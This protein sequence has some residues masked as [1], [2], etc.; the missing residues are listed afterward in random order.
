MTSGDFIDM[1]TRDVLEVLKYIM[2][3]EVFQMEVPYSGD[4][5]HITP[6]NEEVRTSK[7]L[8]DSQKTEQNKSLGHQLGD[9]NIADHEQI[10]NGYKDVL[11]KNS[12]SMKIMES[13]QIGIRNSIGSMS[14][15][16]ERDILMKDFMTVECTKFSYHDTTT[17]KQSEF[18]FK[19]Y[20]P[21][22]F[23][24]FRG[25]FGI[26]HEDFVTSI[27]GGPLLE[28][29]NPGVSGSIFYISQKDKFIT[30]TVQ[31][32]EAT[33]LQ[34]LLPGY[35]LNLNQN[36]DTLLPKFFGLYCYNC[37]SKNVRM[38]VMNNI[39]PYSES[40]HLKYD[41]KGSRYMR[42]ASVT[43]RNKICPT[44]KDLDFLDHHPGGLFL[45]YDD[46]LKLMN[47][48]QRDVRVLERFHIMDYSLLIGI[49]FVETTVKYSLNAGSTKQK[50]EPKGEEGNLPQGDNGNRIHKDN[51]TVEE[52]KYKHR[53]VDVDETEN[54]L[55]GFPAKL[56]NGEDVLVYAGIIDI[57]Q[58][59][60]FKKKIEHVWKSILHNAD[61]VSVHNPAF[62]AKRFIEFLTKFVFKAL[63]QSPKSDK[64]R[65]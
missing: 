35:F 24:Y 54:T 7:L 61:D 63:P 44:Y 4:E 9:E 39:L 41:L 60:R 18:L 55:Q 57:L 8:F 32:K 56:G 5:Y 14:S 50:E 20:A 1:E 46:Y 19:T 13:L 49:T 22:A 65:V 25:L 15:N 48:L 29:P 42:K 43:E 38:V 47:T 30:K 53:I 21:L 28:L 36:P 27:C 52:S 2:T 26:K 17:L 3:D 51:I 16:F 6:T 12:C 64:R 37:H 40:I 45:H 34:E 33:F 31:Q 11:Y 58:S 62:Y 23:G 10:S 59:Y